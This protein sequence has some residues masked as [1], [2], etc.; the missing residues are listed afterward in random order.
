MKRTTIVLTLLATTVFG[1]VVPV[2]REEV[3][4]RLQLFLLDVHGGTSTLPRYADEL[5]RERGFSRVQLEGM[6]LEAAA[7][8]SRDDF[9]RCNAIVGFI[10]I[11][12]PGDLPRLDPFY[13]STNESIRRSIQSFMLEHLETVPEKLAYAR[14]RLDWLAEHPEFQSDVQSISIRLRTVLHYEQP[15]EPDRRLIMDFFR[16]EATNASFARSAYEANSLLMQDDPAWPTNE[17]RRAM[18][19]KWKDDPSLHEITRRQWAEVLASFDSHSAGSPG[20]KG[21]S[22]VTSDSPSPAPAEDG[23]ETDEA[24]SETLRPSEPDTTAA[25]EARPDSRA[26]WKTFVFGAAVSVL[27]LVLSKNVYGFQKMSRHD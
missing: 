6:L 1:E 3:L 17:A 26:G 10:R 7:D 27:L 2:S 13:A 12:Q 5:E 11:A 16:N 21:T 23:A 22:P 24:P 4:D 8:E 15:S 25:R 14:T 18:M 9:P 19:R 20:E